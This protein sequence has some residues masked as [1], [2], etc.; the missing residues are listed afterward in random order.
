MITRLVQYVDQVQTVFL[1]HLDQ[2]LRRRR[3]NTDRYPGIMLLKIT[4]DQ[5]KP[6]KAQRL[7]GA[8]MKRI[9]QLSL[10]CQRKLCPVHLLKNIMG[11]AKEPLSLS[12]Q[13]HLLSD[14]VKQA[15]IQLLLQQTDL[16]G[17]CRLGIAQISR[18]SGK[19]LHL[20]DLHKGN[21]LSDFHK[22][23][24]FPPL[25]YENFSMIL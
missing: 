8:D 1:H 20:N 4:K 23:P 19:A 13:L 2:L 17:H 25:Y 7:D 14:P 15:D 12:C 5:R 22:I 6:G 10:V 9:D 16:H 24:P 3:R 18:R 21:Q 11:I